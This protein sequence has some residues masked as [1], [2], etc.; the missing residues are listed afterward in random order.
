MTPT[1]RARL[2]VHPLTSVVLASLAFGAGGCDAEPPV[3][4]PGSSGERECLIDIDVRHRLSVTDATDSRLPTGTLLRINA[5]GIETGT[6]TA[7]PLA[8]GNT[9]P[10]G[11]CWSPG[12]TIRSV[13]LEEDLTHATTTWPASFR[14]VVPSQNNIDCSKATFPLLL[15]DTDP[16][17]DPSFP[18]VIEFLNLPGPFPRAARLVIDSP[19]D[20]SRQKP[21]ALRFLV[22]DGIGRLEKTFWYANFGRLGANVPAEQT[23][24]MANT[25]DAD[26]TVNRVDALSLDPT[27][28]DLRFAGHTILAG[29]VVK[30]DPPV[31]IPARSA[32]EFR[33]QY[34]ANDQVPAVGDVY[35]SND[36][37]WQTGANWGSARIHL[38]ANHPTPSE[39]E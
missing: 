35:L 29:Q 38:Q 23:L 15:P 6:T 11:R 10:F 32:V 36:S 33:A 26:L 30:L 14:C 20:D 16:A 7:I 27:R 2:F 3:L 4:E 31:V 39:W 18:I 24:T 34:L 1:P 22:M 28:F 9:A 13:T 21:Y 5:R 25:G 12:L 19:D 8:L 37:P 17:I